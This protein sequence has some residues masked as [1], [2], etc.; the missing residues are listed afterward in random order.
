MPNNP[1]Q[2]S[3]PGEEVVKTEW[4]EL[5][6]AEFAPDTGPAA[7]AESDAGYEP[8]ESTPI[9]NKPE[10]PAPATTPDMDSD[11][12]TVEGNEPVAKD[13]EYEQYLGSV[14][15]GQAG[16]QETGA[17]TY[18]PSDVQPQASEA[19][20]NDYLGAATSEA[21]ADVA[22][23]YLGD[24]KPQPESDPLADAYVASLS[25]QP[26]APAQPEVPAQP[27]AESMSMEIGESKEELIDK[28]T[29]VT[30][31]TPSSEPTPEASM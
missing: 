13:E 15:S 9:S 8:I 24:T 18:A 26:E 3:T 27:E 11:V 31:S 12:P 23:E 4:D 20:A 7:D 14:I 1:N 30:E 5:S 6:Q 28:S 21:P 25:T 16:Q 10:A 2:P 22:E 19:S 17:D 29:E